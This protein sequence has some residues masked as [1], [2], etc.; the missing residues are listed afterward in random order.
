MIEATRLAKSSDDRQ[1][2]LAQTLGFESQQQSTKFLG[3]SSPSPFRSAWYHLTIALLI[4]EVFVYM[5][6]VVSSKFSGLYHP[7]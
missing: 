1:A 7:I 3:T 2:A 5:A 4:D 6:A